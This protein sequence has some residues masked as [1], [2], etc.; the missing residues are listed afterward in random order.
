MIGFP[1]SGKTTY[2]KDLDAK[3]I[4]AEDLWQMTGS[5]SIDDYDIYAE[6]C[7]IMGSEFLRRGHDVVI[8]MCNISKIARREWIHMARMNEAECV[9]I[10]LDTPFS[11]CL[12]RNQE[13]GMKVPQ[14]AMKKYYKEL[15]LPNEQEGFDR[16]EHVRYNA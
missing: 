2:C 15:E 7:F 16:I 13:R 6:V 11:E 10:F 1:A 12:L 9:A 3:R 4:S 8:D 5:F 14:E